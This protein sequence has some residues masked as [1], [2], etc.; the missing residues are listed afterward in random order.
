[1]K[2]IETCLLGHRAM[3][4][5]VIVLFG[6]V[7]SSTKEVLH[8][9]EKRGTR[10]YKSLCV[11][12]LSGRIYTDDDTW[13]RPAGRRVEFCRCEK[14]RSRCHSVPFMDCTETKCYN[15][16]LCVK[17]LYSPNYLCKCHSGFTGEHCEIDTLASCY[18]GTGQS[19]RGNYSRTNSGLSCVNWNSQSLSQKIYNAQHKDA[20]Q[21]GLGNHNYCRNPDGDKNPWCYIFKNGKYSWDYCSVPACRA[22]TTHCYSERGTTYRG[23]WSTAISGTSCLRWDSPLLKKKQFSAW[24]TSARRLGLGSH[25]NCRNP[26]ND[27]RPWC[28][29]M[30]GTEISWEFCDV[31]RCTTCG[32]RRP[33]LNPR[34]RIASGRSA[35]ITSHPWTAAI[36]RV[37]RGVE[38]F[39]C[40]GTLINPCWVV[41]A[42]H[43]FHEESSPRLLRVK[44]GRTLQVVPGEEEQS[45]RVEQFHIHPQFEDFTFDND[46]A[47]LK[48]KSSSGSCAME[49][50]SA[51]AA[52][53][54]VR[55]QMLPDW[56]ECEISGFGKHARNSP[57]LSEQLKEGRVR[58]YPDKLC[59]P[60][61]LANRLVTPN[62]LC[63]GD[64]VNQ[65]DACQGDSG[66]PLVCSVD[67]RMHLFGVIS[68][69]EDCGVKDKP[70]VYT[71]VTRYIDWIQDKTGIRLN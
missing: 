25:N 38:Y 37:S 67:G 46:I 39:R 9:R 61:Q 52:C 51:R 29:V 10:T 66:G 64:S 24:Q 31:P 7:V 55:D 11:E 54:P 50:D 26:D 8:N 22:N 12:K 1:M 44:L 30:N 18:E 62:M 57:F 41:T 42:A 68:W 16:G 69:G 45:F 32:I 17:A 35:H 5:L 48:L 70:G 21:L 40:G 47:L 33:Q 59:T 49:T 34:F 23:S 15:G 2:K 43:C 56:T 6:E 20:Q 53:M 27:V 58:L 3:T 19:Y 4:I 65:D 60:K 71:R 36:F 63:A 28:N 13:L 14:G